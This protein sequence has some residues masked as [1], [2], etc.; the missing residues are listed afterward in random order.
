L[1]IADHQ[2]SGVSTV[3]VPRSLSGLAYASVG[4]VTGT[5]V[6][7]KEATYIRGGLKLALGLRDRTAT[8][9]STKLSDS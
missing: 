9:S 7:R 8:S 1:Q 5:N 2:S 6:A 3:L 4:R